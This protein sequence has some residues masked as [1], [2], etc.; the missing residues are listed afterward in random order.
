MFTILAPRE[1]VDFPAA[2]LQSTA[3]SR[4]VSN[5]FLFLG[6]MSLFAKTKVSFGH[7]VTLETCTCGQ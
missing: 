1:R 6:E 7:T 3:A 4:R 2:V 5:H